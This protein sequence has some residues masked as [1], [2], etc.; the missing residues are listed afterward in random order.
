MVSLTSLFLPL[1]SVIL[2][3]L[4]GRKIGTIGSII[5]SA[6]NLCV[7]LLL[8]VFFLLNSM[9]VTAEV[10]LWDWFAL[11]TFITP[12]GFRFDQNTAIMFLVVTL[13]S[14]C[15]HVYSSVYMY[16]DPSLSRFMAYLSFFTL[17]ML[18]LVS[19][20]NFVVLFLG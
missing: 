5:V 18:V 16:G 13:V 8:S 11:P 17:F 9:K 14:S 3:S 6:T 12:V 2:I 4:F 10:E 19:A 20:S 7:A 1:L 15:V